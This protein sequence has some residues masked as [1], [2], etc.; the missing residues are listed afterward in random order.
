MFAVLIAVVLAPFLDS[1]LDYKV[2]RVLLRVARHIFL[3]VEIL[4]VVGHL[5]Y[6]AV[7]EVVGGKCDGT[8]QNAPYI[9]LI[10]AVF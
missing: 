2:R 9:V 7:I 4:V 6:I 1:L 10:F 8:A 3:V 5:L